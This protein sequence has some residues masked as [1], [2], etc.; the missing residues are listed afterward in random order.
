MGASVE[1]ER[2][3]EQSAEQRAAHDRQTAYLEAVRKQGGKV[4]KV[5]EDQQCVIHEDHAAP[6]HFPW[7]GNCH[8]Y[9]Q[10]KDKEIKRGMKLVGPCIYAGKVLAQG[11]TPDKC[12]GIT[13]IERTA[14]GETVVKEV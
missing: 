9:Q 13:I 1:Y 4:W 3:M 14:D 7:C 12:P 2:Q 5:H 10:Y 6:G 11:V 8:N